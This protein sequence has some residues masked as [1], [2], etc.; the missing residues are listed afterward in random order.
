MLI[1]IRRSGIS[2]SGGSF[3]ASAIETVW[4]KGSAVP[5]VDARRFRK[6]GCGAWMERDKYGD[7]TPTGMGWE[8]DH[9]LPVS[10]GG[11]DDIWN[12]Q[13]LQ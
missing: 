4:L 8:I 1:G 12:L 9:I 13:P 5:G 11:T 2:K 3:G 6:D 7:T 10:Q